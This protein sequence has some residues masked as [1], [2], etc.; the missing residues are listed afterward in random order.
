MGETSQVQHAIDLFRSTFPQLDKD[1]ADYVE[2]VLVENAAHF[3]TEA[4]VHDAIGGLLNEFSCG[5]NKSE[6]DELCKEIYSLMKSTQI[7]TEDATL[8]APVH[9]ASLLDTFSERLVDNQSIWMVKREATSVVDKKKLVKAEAK[10][11]E[12]QEKKSSSAK[13]SGLPSSSSLNSMENG[14]NFAT[15]SQQLDRRDIN[16]SADASGRHVGDIRLENFDIAYGSRTLLQGANLT[17]SYGRR[18][19]LIGRNGYGKTT[20]L[21]ALARGDLRLPSGLRILHVE[22]EMAGDSTPALESVLRADTERAA[23]LAELSQLQ[24]TRSA[25]TNPVTNGTS[26]LIP[27]NDTASGDRLSQVY[28]RLTAIEADKAPARAAVILHGLGFDSEMQQRPTKQFSGGWRMR[29]SLAQALFS[30]PDLLLLDEPTNML[31]MRALIWLEGYLQTSSNILIIVSHDRSFL[32][33]VATDIIHLTARRLDMYR[34]NYDAFEQARGDRLLAQQREYEAQKA[35][36]EHIQQFIDKFRYNAKRASLVQSRIKQLERLPPLVPPEKDPTVVIRF[37]ACDKLSSPV[38]Q[39]D[40]VSFHY[41]P[42]KP[43]LSKVDL[44]I[45]SDSR[46]CVVG[47]NGAGKT[48]LLRILLGQLEP[49]SGLRHA[50]RGLRLGY[51]SQHHVDQ[52]DLGLNSLEFLM[53]KFPGQTEQVYRSQL[54]GFNITDMLAMQPIG[55]LSGG[56]KS[57]VAFAAMCMSNPNMLVLDEPTNHLDVETIAALADALL[58]FQGG[59]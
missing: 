25:G 1:V 19:G 31:D 44:S 24:S 13:L 56:Q 43:V 10:L 20:L 54:A 2:G 30:K 5:A 32:N 17:V 26:E 41:L 29:L 57:R 38:L 3:D 22:Q 15:V 18:Y 12:K 4:E 8:D 34:G 27:Q 49:T 46:I 47:E 35:E 50:H 11:R 42:D 40:E 21:R 52:L 7:K 36:R 28:S 48:T 16:A 9:M 58:S 6:I 51:F 55:S 53:R 23:L 37:P 45:S 59:V 33:S 14:D 39:L